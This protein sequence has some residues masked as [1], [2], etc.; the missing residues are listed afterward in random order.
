MDGSEDFYRNWQDYKDGF[1]N[2]TAEFWLGTWKVIILQTYFLRTQHMLQNN[3]VIWTVELCA[4]LTATF[5][6]WTLIGNHRQAI[7]RQASY[8]SYNPTALT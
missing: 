4:L 3:I 6:Q 7:D 2:L 8:T 5:Y 1:G